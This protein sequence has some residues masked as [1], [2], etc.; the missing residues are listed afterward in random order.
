MKFES[1]RQGRENVLCTAEES[2]FL[3]EVSEVTVVSTHILGHSEERT[4]LCLV[5]FQYL[6]HPGLSTEQN[7]KSF[8]QIQPPGRRLTLLAIGHGVRFSRVRGFAESRASSCTKAS[9]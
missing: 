1:R 9:F 8:S 4:D 3:V 5:S 7:S 6:A 2:G